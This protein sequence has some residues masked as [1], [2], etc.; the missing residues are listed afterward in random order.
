MRVKLQGEG[1][2]FLNDILYNLI[3]DTCLKGV[4][5]E[6]VTNRSILN[7]EQLKPLERFKNLQLVFS[8]DAA[9]GR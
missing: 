8:M 4:W 3:E 6:V 2:P 7:A 9:T 1:E 5:C